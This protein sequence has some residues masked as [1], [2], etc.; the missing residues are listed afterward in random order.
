MNKKTHPIVQKLILVS[1]E[2]KKNKIRKAP[3]YDK[4]EK[5]FLNMS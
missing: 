4:P 2:N 5:I 1:E 3:D